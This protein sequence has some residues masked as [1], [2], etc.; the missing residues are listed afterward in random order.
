MIMKIKAGRREVKC[1]GYVFASS[2]YGTY[3][4]SFIRAF[5]FCFAFSFLS[6]TSRAQL[7]LN[8]ANVPGATIQFNGTSSS[9]QFNSSTTVL[10]PPFGSYYVGSQ[11]DITSE[12]PQS[13]TASIGL[14][15]VFNTNQFFYGGITTVIGGNDTNETAFVNLNQPGTMQINDGMGK[16]LTGNVNW[17][18]VDTHNYVGGLNAS[19]MV[20]V[21]NVMYSGSNPDLQTLNANQPA[22]MDLSFQFS[23]GMMLTDLTSGTGPYASSFSGSISVVPEPGTL[24]LVGMGLLGLLALGRRRNK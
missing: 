14:L 2:Q 7:T 8:F 6:F 22:S 23:P 9:F 21:T 3:K 19:L 24:T 5:L 12:N 20:N 17:V 15:G 1:S 18:E 13:D 10:G 11:W 4:S 16:Y